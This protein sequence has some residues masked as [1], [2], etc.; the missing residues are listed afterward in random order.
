[1]LESSLRPFPRLPPLIPSPP[2]PPFPHPL[3]T[4]YNVVVTDVFPEKSFE[5][6]S[7]N[8]TI[9]LPQLEA[10]A[11]FTS[12]LELVP[13]VAGQLSVA[14]AEV[15][16]KYKLRDEL[17]LETEDG[18]DKKD[19]GS[20]EEEEALSASSSQG[21]VDI[22]SPEAYALQGKNKTFFATIFVVHL[23]LFAILAPYSQLPSHSHHKKGQ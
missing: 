1:M 23:A 14:R 12:R 5:I 9:T 8:P 4:A 10:G 13:K 6:K 7:G 3:S 20:M 16:Y 22:L 19:A 2:S 15:R 17:E 11:N 21:K 18:E